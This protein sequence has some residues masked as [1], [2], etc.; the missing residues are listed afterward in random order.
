LG[1][2]RAPYHVDLSFHLQMTAWALVDLWRRQWR[3]HML[4]T[5]AQWLQIVHKF[6]PFIP[7]LYGCVIHIRLYHGKVDGVPQLRVP[8]TR[9]SA[10]DSVSCTIR[11]CTTSSWRPSW[12]GMVDHW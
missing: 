9:V 10:W 4:F 2:D 7:S 1:F 5:F 8:S 12:M 11:W 6:E 3:G